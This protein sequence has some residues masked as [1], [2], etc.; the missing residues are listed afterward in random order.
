MAAGDP[1]HPRPRRRRCRGA[2]QGGGGASCTL[3]CALLRTVRRMPPCKTQCRAQEPTYMQTA[4]CL[5]GC[6][7]YGGRQRRA[8]KTSALSQAV[9]HPFRES[10]QAQE[11]GFWPLCATRPRCA[12]SAMPSAS[13]LSCNPRPPRC[14]HCSLWMQPRR[15]RRGWPRSP[16]SWCAQ[17]G[18][19][20][21]CARLSNHSIR[22]R[23]RLRAESGC[24]QAPSVLELA[25][26]ATVFSSGGKPTLW[27]LARP[28]LRC[29]QRC[30]LRE[31]SV[32]GRAAAGGGARARRTT[33]RRWG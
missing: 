27:A 24:E 17:R 7:E 11:T 10:P 25:A 2:E 1:C 4:V 32:G 30:C 15:R 19:R 12:L 22:S 29:I 21:I 31:R 23:C 16:P 18:F 6:G 5:Q 13:A 3:C 26:A 28:P 9:C 8:G 33:I 20:S 14:C